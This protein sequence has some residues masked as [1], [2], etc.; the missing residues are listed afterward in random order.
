M[1]LDVN[2]RSPKEGSCFLSTRDSNYNFTKIK[3]RGSIQPRRF[4]IIKLPLLKIMTV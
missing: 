4:V 1:R 2:E 3:R